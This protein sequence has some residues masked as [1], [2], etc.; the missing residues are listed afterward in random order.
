M[1]E[2]GH[3]IVE[4]TNDRTV[5]PFT[6]VIAEYRK[7]AARTARPGRKPSPTVRQ[8]NRTKVVLVKH[9]PAVAALIYYV[10]TADQLENLNG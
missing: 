1:I 8:R 3:I 4:E 5:G 9:Q 2:S 6:A 10:G 7:H